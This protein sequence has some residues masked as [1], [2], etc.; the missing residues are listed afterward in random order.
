ME[1]CIQAHYWKLEWHCKINE[2]GFCFTSEMELK[3]LAWGESWER[4]GQCWFFHLLAFGAHGNHQT[5]PDFHHTWILMYIWMY[6]TYESIWMTIHEKTAGSF[7]CSMCCN[8]C[9]LLLIILVI[10][11]LALLNS[12]KAAPSHKGTDCRFHQLQQPSIFATMLWWFYYYFSRVKVSVH[13]ATTP[14]GHF[15]DEN[16][17]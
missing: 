4:R 6:T 11:N 9:N 16:D 7:K 2:N 15:Q 13:D 5:S 3:V 10:N 1:C 12:L 14:T 17:C 8:S